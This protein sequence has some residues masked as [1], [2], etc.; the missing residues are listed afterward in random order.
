MRQ[1]NGFLSGASGWQ[2]VDISAELE[3]QNVAYEQANK[4]DIE[5]STFE[6]LGLNTLS[7]IIKGKE[8]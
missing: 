8:K 4:K 2:E 1:L 3:A 7:G 5:V 6:S